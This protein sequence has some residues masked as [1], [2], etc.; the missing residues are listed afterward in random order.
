MKMTKADFKKTACEMK[1]KGGPASGMTVV[2]PLSSEAGLWFVHG[3]K[4][5]TYR[6]VPGRPGTSL[7]YVSAT[8]LGAQTGT[9]VFDQ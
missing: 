7:E 6:G 9:L 2:M 5:H 4:V 8:A 3:G 1:L